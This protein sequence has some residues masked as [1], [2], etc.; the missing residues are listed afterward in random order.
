MDR[1][2]VTSPDIGQKPYM[3]MRPGRQLCT[4]E[5]E[6]VPMKRQNPQTFD[7][8]DH[9]AEE[10]AMRLALG[11]N[12]PVEPP[13]F[14]P[15][16]QARRIQVHPTEITH[17][18]QA[19]HVPPFTD[20]SQQHQVALLGDTLSQRVYPAVPTR[21][22]IV[23]HRPETEQ[24]QIARHPE[25]DLYTE[26]GGYECDRTMNNQPG[27]HSHAPS[28]DHDHHPHPF[29]Q[30][31]KDI[32]YNREELTSQER[33][34]LMERLRIKLPDV[35]DS[36]IESKLVECNWNVEE[37]FQNVRVIQM[38]DLGLEGSTYEKCHR[39]LE[40]CQWKIDRAA[41]WLMDSTI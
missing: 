28:L 8:H 26:N 39:A 41:T 21:S 15:M 1:L 33:S 7:S 16:G 30:L 29:V 36:D 27:Q 20:F 22:Q 10:R 31:P 14:Q 37:A 35:Q 25:F 23:P 18:P 38:L 2:S 4:P 32:S 24:S 5:E 17:Q 12:V 9:Q 6:Y 11:E 13:P 19:S 40:H 34:I 3:S